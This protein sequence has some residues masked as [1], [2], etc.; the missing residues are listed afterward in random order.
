MGGVDHFIWAL[1][2]LCALHRLPFSEALLTQ[3]VPPPYKRA[4]LIEAAQRLGFQVEA[5]SV[6][7]AQTLASSTQASSHAPSF[8]AFRLAVDQGQ[9]EETSE[10]DSADQAI[11]AATDAFVLIGKIEAERVVYFEPGSDQPHIAPD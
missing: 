6:S 9:T 10:S 8:L 5:V 3:Q 1:G 4:A 11:P 2:S 7:V